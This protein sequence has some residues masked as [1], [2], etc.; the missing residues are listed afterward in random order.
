MSGRRAPG[1]GSI[2]QRADGRWEGSLSAGW[3]ASGKRRRRKVVAATRREV[4]ERLAAL[5]AEVAAGLTA[6]GSRLSVADWLYRWLAE[7]VR[8]SVRPR[9]YQAYETTVRRHL[10]P[11]LGQIRLQKLTPADV[12]A[13]MQR[14]LAA[15]LTPCSVRNGHSVL[16]RALEIAARYDYATR[17]V[18][19]LVSPPRAVRGE[20]HPLDS[21]E[22]HRFLAAA[23]GHRLEALYVLAA[24]TGMRLGEVLGLTWDAVDLDGGF[25]RVEHSLA[26]YDSAYHL[27]APKTARS[28]RAI[29]IAPPVVASLHSRRVRQRERRLAAGPAWAGNDWDLVFTTETGRPLSPSTVQVIFGRLLD[30]AGVRRVVFH[31]LRHGAATFLLVRGVPMKVVQDILGHSQ[32][33]MTADI[34]SHVIPELRRDAADRIG[35]A[36]FGG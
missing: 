9:S 19:R 3:G 4:A 22:T 6:D 25:V 16:R 34:Y 8:P 7:E 35:A 20:V 1:E 12:R 29:A 10:V 30:Q 5:R 24:S 15:G 23:S 2:Y 21:A 26:R 13:F 32:I 31:A 36:L 28:R 18:A 17:N 14:Q 11:G 27:D 33:T